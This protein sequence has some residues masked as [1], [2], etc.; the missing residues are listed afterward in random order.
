MATKQ[1]GPIFWTTRPLPLCLC[2]F[3]FQAPEIRN[4]WRWGSE[5][6]L[7]FSP[8]S[9]APDPGP[10]HGAAERHRVLLRRSR[11]GEKWRVGSRLLGK[12]HGFWVL[13]L[14]LEVFN[15]AWPDLDPTW[16]LSGPRGECR[17]LYTH[18]ALTKTY[19]TPFWGVHKETYVQILLH[20][21]STLKYKKKWR[22]TQYCFNVLWTKSCTRSAG[23]RM[24]TG[25]THL[26][27]SCRSGFCASTEF[28]TR[29]TIY[30]LVR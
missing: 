27:G 4:V 12:K 25:M 8:A 7:S 14:I 24:K 10:R 15:D 20:I 18:W 3:F 1:F 21:E 19:S 11:P 9:P 6:F 23:C 13:F 16:L 5:L 2:L 29:F 30:L 26:P 17:D 22:R 28:L